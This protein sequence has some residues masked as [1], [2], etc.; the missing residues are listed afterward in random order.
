MREPR[1]INTNYQRTG[2]TLPLGHPG[3]CNASP[4]WPRDEWKSQD[5]E[6]VHPDLLLRWELY[7]LDSFVDAIATLDVATAWVDPGD[8]LP[9][10]PSNSWWLFM[11]NL[12]E[13]FS[14]HLQTRGVDH[15]N[16]YVRAVYDV[17]GARMARGL[18]ASHRPEG[19]SEATTGLSEATP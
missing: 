7:T 10:R 12:S 2:C 17:V 9:R 8:G 1:C 14:V 6:R 4:P 19:L 11:L 15:V 16:R 18:A 13:R 5:C 3:E